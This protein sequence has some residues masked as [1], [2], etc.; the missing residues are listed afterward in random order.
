MW[1]TA[2]CVD[3][4]SVDTYSFVTSHGKRGRKPPPEDRRNN[5]ETRFFGGFF[6]FWDDLLTVLVG[7]RGLLGY[8]NFDVSYGNEFGFTGGELVVVVIWGGCK[9][10][11]T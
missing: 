1:S 11:K 2:G 3:V 6:R 7:P 5:E 4:A 10:L 9:A 8:S